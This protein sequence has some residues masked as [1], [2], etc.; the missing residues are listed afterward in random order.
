MTHFLSI[1][2]LI[3][4]YKAN[5]IPNYHTLVELGF[6]YSPSFQF[7]LLHSAIYTQKFQV[8]SS[9]RQLIVLFHNLLFSASK[10]EHSSKSSH[11]REYQL[12]FIEIIVFF[13]DYCCSTHRHPHFLR[14]EYIIVKNINILPVWAF[15]F[16]SVIST[17]EINV[18][19]V[20]LE[21]EYRA[22]IFSR[23]YRRLMWASSAVHNER[24]FWVQVLT[25]VVYSFHII[26]GIP[27]LKKHWV[28]IFRGHLGKINRTYI[29]RGRVSHIY[30]EGY[31]TSCRLLWCYHIHQK[32]EIVGF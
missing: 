26:I 11:A 31:E 7:L 1:F 4:A 28:I 16:L 10:T 19:P 25:G 8:G 27:L 17:P 12:P 9:L 18:R 30:N 21:N 23:M 15:R 2:R 13:V 6:T 29:Y 32:R 3:P 24:F 20:T 14:N 5:W 22:F